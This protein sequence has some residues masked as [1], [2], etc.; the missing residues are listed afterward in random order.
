MMISVEKTY[1]TWSS[2]K[3]W[4]SNYGTDWYLPSI[5]E[6]RAVYRNKSTIDSTL[7]AIGYTILGTSY[8]WSSTEESMTSS[9]I[10]YFVS[11]E[12]A[13]LNSMRNGGLSVRLVKDL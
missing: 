11:F 2:A 13:C 10:F 12:A 9:E 4:C 8:Y 7:S 5:G 1:E 6:L 3:S